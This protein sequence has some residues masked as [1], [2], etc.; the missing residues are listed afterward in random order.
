MARL[1]LIDILS[2]LNKRRWAVI[3]P[4]TTASVTAY[5]F[6]KKILIIL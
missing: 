6:A 3:S 1:A 4:P 5:S 2:H